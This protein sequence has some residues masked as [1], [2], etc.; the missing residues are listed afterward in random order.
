MKHGKWI[1]PASL[2][3]LA[4]YVLVYVNTGENWISPRKAFLSPQLTTSLTGLLPKFVLALVLLA[5]TAAL[6]RWYCRLLCPAGTVQEIFSRIGGALTPPRPP[7]R[8]CS[9][10]SASPPSSAC[11]RWRSSPTPSAF[12]PA[13]PCPCRDSSPE[14]KTSSSG[15]S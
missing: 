1:F 2:C 5:L 11:A 7:A 9:A 6:G 14:R 12:S 13:S 15:S 10:S 4:G 3:V 8:S